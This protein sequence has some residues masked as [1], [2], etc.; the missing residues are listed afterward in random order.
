MSWPRRRTKAATTTPTT[1]VSASTAEAAWLSDA[2]TMFHI[3]RLVQASVL[4]GEALAACVRDMMAQRVRLAHSSGLTVTISDAASPRTCWRGLEQVG[5]RYPPIVGRLTVFGVAG[6]PAAPPPAAGSAAA[7]W[8]APCRQMIFLMTDAWDVVVWYNDL[9]FYVAPSMQEFWVSPIVLEY[10]NAV[11]PLSER[12]YVTQYAGQVDDLIQFY[13]RLVYEKQVLENRWNR[14]QEGRICFAKEWNRLQYVLAHGSVVVR[15]GRLPPM[16]VDDETLFRHVTNEEYKRLLKQMILCANCLPIRSH[17]STAPVSSRRQHGAGAAPVYMTVWS[18]PTPPP[19]AAGTTAGTTAGAVAPPPV[20]VTSPWVAGSPVVTV[21]PVITASPVVGAAPVI[22][23]SPVIGTGPVITT[24]PV[25][26]TGPVITTSPVLGTG[27]VITT[28]PVIGAGPVI[29]ASPVVGAAPVLTAS[30]LIGTPPLITTSP[31]SVVAPVLNALP[32]T[33][34]SAAVLEPR[35]RPDPE[36]ERAARD[37]ARLAT[38]RISSPGF[39]TDGTAGRP[40][41]LP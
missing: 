34:D 37:R 27:P 30:P 6:P 24:S 11:F 25:L 36:S 23:A 20:V 8:E 1:T 3:G 39:S 32:V 33:A 26:G 13:H 7:S 21:S 22:T 9:L 17:A 2:A 38:V 35:P 12:S 19:D 4:G 14:S 40:R 28:S 29:T 16:F 41:D 31:G 10:D 18:Y 15:R 5:Q